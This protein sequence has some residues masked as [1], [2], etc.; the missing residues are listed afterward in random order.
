[1]AVILFKNLFLLL[2]HDLFE[3]NLIICGGDSTF[4]F[5]ERANWSVHRKTRI[6]AKSS[7]LEADQT[8]FVHEMMNP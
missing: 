3:G 6:K 8:R 1:M 7:M 2:Q 5:L 4:V